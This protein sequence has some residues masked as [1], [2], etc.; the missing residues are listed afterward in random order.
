MFNKLGM[1]MFVV[2]DMS[3]SVA[4][5]RDVLGLAVRHESPYFSELE[6]G[7]TAIG[8][9]PIG[10]ELKV[11][12]SVGISIGFY[13]TD[14]A[15]ATAEIESRGGTISRRTDES[16]GVLLEI[17]DPDGYLIQVCERWG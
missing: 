13:V 3:R 1:V 9:H 11:N 15:A 6:I 5:Y 4:W 14:A 16:W 12:P 10:Q 17:R 7:G 2:S 8:L